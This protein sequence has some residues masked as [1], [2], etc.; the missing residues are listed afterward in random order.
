VVDFPFIYLYATTDYSLKAK[1]GEEGEG[2]KQ[3]HY[4]PG[5]LVNKKDAFQI[6]IDTQYIVVSSQGKISFYTG[7]GVYKKEFRTQHRHDH[8]FCPSENKII[9]LTAR[10]GTDNIFYL[11][12]NVYNDQFIAEKEIFA[13]KRFSQ[14]PSGD[15]NV[16]YDK[17]IVFD[18]CREK[19]YVTA[20]GREDSVIDVFDLEGKKQHSISHNYDRPAVTQEDKNQ[21]LDFYRTGPLKYIW[22]RFRKQIKFPAHFPGLRN[23]SIDKDKIVVL[24]FKRKNQESEFIIFDLNGKFLKKTMVPL[25]KKDIYFYP[26][27][28]YTGKLYQLV[29]DEDNEKW[30]LRI[31]PIL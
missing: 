20:I 12:L 7:N 28:I 26:Y 3:F 27:T 21:Y 19:I 16:V 29:E 13:C 23:F 4:F 15:I 25:Q 22:D 24:T 2:P 1:I 14:P 31:Y 8:K 18:V 5:S 6:N 17:G 9:G 10:R 11:R 30:E